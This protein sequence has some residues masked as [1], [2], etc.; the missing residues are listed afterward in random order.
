METIHTSWLYAT[1]SYF[2]R[3]KST[4]SIYH[5]LAGSDK[6]FKAEHQFFNLTCLFTMGGFSFFIIINTIFEIDF[7]LTLIKLSVVFTSTILYYYSRIKLK[8]FWTSVLY[9]LIILFSLLFIGVFNGGVTGG[10]APIYTSILVLMLFIMSGTRR[11]FLLTIWALSISV[12]FVTEYYRPDL[13]TPYSSIEQKYI[14]ICL[15]YFSGIIIIAFVVMNVKKLYKKENKVR[16]NVEDLIE[17]YQ[18][19]D[20]ELK[21]I[22][23]KKMNLLSVREREICKL[24]LVGN[25]NREIADSLFITEGTVK[26]HLNNIYKKLGTNNR[27]EVINLIGRNL[28]FL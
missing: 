24:L 21:E 8:F 10:I 14:D 9:F 20:F 22:I 16:L 13:I 5:L 26:C 12:L 18:S 19:A 23:D 28:T 15:S 7:T 3:E 4:N 25:S 1:I 2:S 6:N 27:V 17:Q 11:I